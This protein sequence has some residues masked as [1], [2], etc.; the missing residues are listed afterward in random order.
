MSIRKAASAFGVSKSALQRLTTGQVACFTTAEL[1]LFVRRV[2]E[3]SP[4]KREIHA[5]FPSYLWLAKFIKSNSKHFSRRKAQNLETCRAIA[6]TEENVRS[7]Y[8]NI[9]TAIESCGD[10]PPS[11]IWN[12]DETGMCGQGSRN[13]KVVLASKG[14]RANVQQSDSRD[15]VSALV[16]VNAAGDHCRRSSYCLVTTS[17]SATPAVP[18][19]V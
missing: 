18:W 9:K 5:S 7:H 8:C 1:G 16:C 4:Y 3:E 11:C 2:V 12:L 6:A 10:F 19:R 15:N 17:T 14:K 13:A